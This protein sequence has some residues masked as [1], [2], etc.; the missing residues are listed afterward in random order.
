MKKLVKI[1][2]TSAGAGLLV[3]AGFRLGETLTSGRAVAA[4]PAQPVRT[5]AEP[6]GLASVHPSSHTS[7]LEHRISLLEKEVANHSAGLFELRECSLR[8]ER[9]LQKLLLS[10]DRLITPAQ[11][12]PPPGL[13]ANGS[14]PEKAIPLSQ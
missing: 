6:E 14:T 1:L 13:G 12:A 5:A 8:T 7:S 4:Q 10:I 3:G 11:A 9:S 2:A